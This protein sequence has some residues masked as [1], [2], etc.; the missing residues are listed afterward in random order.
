MTEGERR[1]AAIMFTDMV[2]YTALGQ[3]N[4]S[5]SLALVEEQRR[6]IRPILARHNGR[7]VKTMGDSFL[8]E[9]PNAVDAVRCA[10]DIQRA[11]R[12]LN[13][14]L[15]SDK[16]IHLRIGVHVGE[17]VESERDISGDAVNVASRIEPLAE[18]GGVCVTSHVYDFVRGKVDL[19]LRSVGAKTLKNVSD[20]LEVYRMVM[21]W[22]DGTPSMRLDTR[23]IAVLPLANF[24][25]DPADAYFADG[26]TEEIIS[27]ASNLSGLSVISRTSVMGYKGTA[28]KV[29]EIGRE[30]E[31]GSILE[32]S[33]RKAGNRIR[34][35]AQLIDV[36]EDS[37][38]WSQSYDRDFDDVFAIQS[39]IAMQIANALQVKI[40]PLEEARIKEVPTKST[41]AH[42]LYLKGKHLLEREAD[43]SSMLAAIHLLEEALESDPNYALAYCGLA[44]AYEGLAF[45]EFVDSKDAHAKV[46]RFARKALELDGSLAEGHMA[47]A[48]HLETK[49]DFRGAVEELRRATELS[50]NSA[51]AYGG[52]AAVYAFMTKWDECFEAVEQE[53]RLDPFSAETSQS[54]GTWYLYSG[55]FDEAIKHL[56]RA[57]ELDPGNSFCLGNLGLA[58]IKKGL[59][60][61]GVDELERASKLAGQAAW[62]GA[63]DLAYAYVNVG[64]PQDARKILETLL[65]MGNNTHQPS[66][67]IA[68]IYA[69][70]GEKEKALVWLE[71]A[72]DE[73]STYV[74][75][76]KSDFVFENLR[77]E[78]RF[79]TLVK[80]LGLD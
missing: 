80:K 79:N 60:E 65:A 14:S 71:R 39:D 18:D 23:R 78:P 43:K 41:D 68:G 25:P 69:V 6:V 1:L 17:V 32:G 16:R 29:K 9:F 57:L 72:Y 35:T 27:T 19:P 4:E 40:K 75:S 76:I 10:Y 3:K 45:H 62:G 54:A 24:S 59:V 50:P 70:L 8:V 66:S 7:E 47:L 51:G 74:A 33:F 37:H 15:A 58:H 67:R 48:G 63:A 64:R 5:L 31:A 53:L 61:L 30:L 49:H 26:I 46:E 42:A 11:V 38:V 55:R 77:D 56:K 2:G 21:P 12:E 52:L 20:P 28:K 73:G 44:R 22:E 36:N 13:L 34:V